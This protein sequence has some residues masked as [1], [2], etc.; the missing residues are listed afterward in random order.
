MTTPCI[1]RFHANSSDDDVL[2]GIDLTGKTV[3]ITGTT[4]GLGAE[5]ARALAMRGARVIMANRNMS[6]AQKVKERICDAYPEAHVELLQCDLSSLASVRDA[7]I[8]FLMRY[9]Q[10]HVLILNA[11][12]YGPQPT[13]SRDGYE[14]TFATNHLGHFYLTK[15]LMNVLRSSAPSRVVVVSSICHANTK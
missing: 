5:T 6:A 15:L 2:K 14:N 11:G 12:V 8:A 4:S 9:K 3:L 13:K 7:A 1:R 10:L